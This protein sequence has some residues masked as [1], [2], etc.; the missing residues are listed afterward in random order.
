D[1]L[2]RRAGAAVDRVGQRH[3][4]GAAAEVVREVLEAVGAVIDGLVAG[5]GEVDGTEHP[6][7]PAVWLGGAR[8]PPL[9]PPPPPPGRWGRTLRAGSWTA[10][11][12]TRRGSRPAAVPRAKPWP[13]RPPRSAAGCTAAPAAGRRAS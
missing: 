11:T 8:G 9:L 2:P 7:A 6:P 3:E 5:F 13:R 1:A 12:V 10:T 4:A